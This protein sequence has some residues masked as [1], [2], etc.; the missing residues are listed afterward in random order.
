ME[1]FMERIL[2][3]PAETAD[4][5]GVSRARVYQLLRAGELPS[6]LVGGRLRIPV[7]Q[8]RQWVREQTTPAS[9]TTHVE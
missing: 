4:A 7:E 8:L 5:I 9:G 3:R 2:L 6:I 1:A